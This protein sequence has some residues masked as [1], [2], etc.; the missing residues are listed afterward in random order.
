HLSPSVLALIILTWSLMVVSD[1]QEG[2]MNF[3]MLLP[4]VTGLYLA[5]RETP[6]ADLGAGTMIALA[7]AVKVTPIVFV[8]YFFWRRRWRIVAMAA[9]GLLVWWFVVPTIAFGWEQNW[10]WFG[11]WSRIMLLP[12]I[13]KG[14]IVYATSLSVPSFALR[15][16]SHQPAFHTE[17]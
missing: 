7:I 10:K 14:T 13:V 4:L 17:H 8:A 6:A 12:Y 1:M 16:L 3:A 2:Q 11:Q 5:Q 9:A 15:L